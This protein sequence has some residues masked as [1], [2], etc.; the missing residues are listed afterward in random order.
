M[1]PD[2]DRGP[3][4]QIDRKQIAMTTNTSLQQGSL[5]RQ[6][7]FGLGQILTTPTW[8][9]GLYVII[10]T[11]A[12]IFTTYTDPRWGVG[13]HLLLLV[14]L[15]IHIGFTRSGDTGVDR[16]LIPVLFAPIIRILSMS[17]PL[18]DFPRITWYMIVA[19]PIF[20]VV[21]QVRSLLDYS[22]RDI[23]FKI[24]WDTLRFQLIIIFSGVVFGVSEYFILRPQPF[25][26]DLTLAQLL[27]PALILL[28]GTGVMEEVVFRGLMQKSAS[29]TLGKWGGL[30]FASLIFAVLHIGYQSMADLMFVFTAGAFWGWVWMRTGSLWSISLAHGITNILLFLVIPFLSPLPLPA[31]ERLEGGLPIEATDLQSLL[32][33]LA[34]E[35]TNINDGV[36]VLF[37]SPDGD[38]IIVVIMIVLLAVLSFVGIAFL[39]AQ[40]LGARQTV[41]AVPRKTTGL[42][43][44]TAGTLPAVQPARATPLPEDARH[45]DADHDEAVYREFLES[46]PQLRFHSLNGDVELPTYSVPYAPAAD[47]PYL[48]KLPIPLNVV[49]KHPDSGEYFGMQLAL[50]DDLMI[51]TGASTPGN[52][53]LNLGEIG[54]ADYGVAPQHCII[55]YSDAG[56]HLDKLFDHTVIV[57]GMPLEK[58]QRI[59]HQMHVTLGDNVELIF[60]LPNTNE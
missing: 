22:W 37:I 23:G 27:I 16:L 53:T 59:Q 32:A 38:N 3:V 56:A 46:G 57:N 49:V 34:E 25:I 14:L 29:E 12:E 41:P 11:L 50:Y 24:G 36:G 48:P 15:V 40:A 1:R 6:N 26:G 60:L 28:I 39:I 17:L 42:I 51:G 18:A 19:I 30:L 31:P 58:P 33:G 54:A 9:A 43:P 5:E 7:S 10:I 2:R 55:H 52:L 45:S 13:A 4:T 21:P 35:N 20:A 8:V 44:V 47:D